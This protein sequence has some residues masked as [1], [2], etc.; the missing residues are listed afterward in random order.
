LSLLIQCYGGLF[1]FEII[2]CHVFMCFCEYNSI[3]RD[4]VY[5]I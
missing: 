4:I 3:D 1:F 2:T 5:N